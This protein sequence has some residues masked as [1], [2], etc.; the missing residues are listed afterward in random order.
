MNRDEFN[1][2]CG[3]L[4]A[5]TN[6]VQWGNASVWKVGGKIFAICSIWGD[7]THQKISF[8]CSDLRYQILCEL[9]GMVPAP[10]LARA[11]WV[12]VQAPGALS[13]DDIKSCIE[14]AHAIIARKLTKKLRTELGLET[15][16]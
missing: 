8:K 9:P 16:A 15:I 2:Y 13:D 3:R 10:Y 5:S 7:E 14:D 11:K 1:T 4:K 12:Q 6:V